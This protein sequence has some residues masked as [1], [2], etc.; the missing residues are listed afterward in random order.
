MR[1][2]RDL[3]LASQGARLYFVTGQHN[4]YPATNILNRFV[5]TTLYC[6]Y[7]LVSGKYMMTVSQW[8]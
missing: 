7:S 3:S 8:R 6:R 2:K 1:E 5:H 4:N